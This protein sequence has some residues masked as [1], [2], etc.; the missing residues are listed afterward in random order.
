M[1]KWSDAELTLTVPEADLSQ[2]DE[3]HVTIAQGD[4]YAVD[5]EVD[6][7]DVVG[8]HDLQVRLNQRQTAGFCLNPPTAEIQV[9]FMAGG[10]RKNTD[11]VSIPVKNNLLKEVIGN[12]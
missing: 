8:Q 12:E 1:T 3:I 4:R 7:S 6:P 5:I 11:I 2:A 10:I 9:N